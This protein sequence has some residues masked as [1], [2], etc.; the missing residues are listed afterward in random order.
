MYDEELKREED[1]LRENFD[2]L[3]LMLEEVEQYM[4]HLV[5][6][7]RAWFNRRIDKTLK[8]MG[9]YEEDYSWEEE[10]TKWHI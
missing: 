5:Q 1:E 2:V 10:A 6:I 7:L 9:Q 3:R 8:R 4:P